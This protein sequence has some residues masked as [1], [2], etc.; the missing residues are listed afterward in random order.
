LEPE[1]RAP[2]LQ[3]NINRY[4]PQAG[5]GLKIFFIYMGGARPHVFIRKIQ[6]E[7]D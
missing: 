7:S 4:N 3:K 2:Q 1:P 5:A 6:L